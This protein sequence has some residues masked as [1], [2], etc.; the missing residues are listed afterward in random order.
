MECYGVQKPRRT[1]SGHTADTQRAHSGHTVGTQED[2]IRANKR[3]VCHLFALLCHI[4]GGP[5]RGHG[6]DFSVGGPAG[7]RASPSG[8][9]RAPVE[10]PMGSPLGAR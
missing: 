10:V 1:H 5:P 8:P 9:R 3:W 7:P 6:L 2:N 4:L